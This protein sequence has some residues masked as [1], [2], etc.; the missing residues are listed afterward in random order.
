MQMMLKP[1]KWFSSMMRGAMGLRTSG[2][3]DLE[4]TRVFIMFTK[5]E[6]L[7]ECTK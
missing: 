2:P 7:N 5:L 3:K 6:E 1:Q 4:N